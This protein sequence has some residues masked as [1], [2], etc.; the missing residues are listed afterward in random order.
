[1]DTPADFE[2]VL[3]NEQGA[4]LSGTVVSVGHPFAGATVRM[5]RRH[6]EWD[7]DVNVEIRGNEP[8]PFGA[9]GF[10]QIPLESFE[11]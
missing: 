11:R 1:M 2:V 10:A 8:E 3:D 7:G 6:T 5:S 9:T 4:G